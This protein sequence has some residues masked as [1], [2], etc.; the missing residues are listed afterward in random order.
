ML[1]CYACVRLAD[2]LLAD[3]D[4]SFEYYVLAGFTSNNM[5]VHEI[6]GEM[7]LDVRCKD[8]PKSHEFANTPSGGQRSTIASHISRLS[9][10]HT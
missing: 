10:A 8:T 5:R 6:F 7:R 1:G 4:H 2:K 9:I 3:A